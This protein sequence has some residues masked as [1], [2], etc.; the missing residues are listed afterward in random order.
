VRDKKSSVGLV[1]IPGGGGGEGPLMS[2]RGRWENN[3]SK[4]V[5]GD[6]LD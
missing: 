2:R 3:K 1:G 4:N 6:G 5:G